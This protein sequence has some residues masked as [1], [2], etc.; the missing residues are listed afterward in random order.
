[1]TADELN[2]AIQRICEERGM[3]FAP[4][5]CHPADANDGP[6]RGRL[7][8]LVQSHGRRRRRCDGS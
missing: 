1:M 7:A 8:V 3:N 2:E 6:C 5:E 4:W